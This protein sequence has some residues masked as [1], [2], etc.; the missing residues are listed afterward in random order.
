[1]TDDFLSS[2]PTEVYSS[3]ICRH[4]TPLLMIYLLLSS[5]C[6]RLIDWRA[7][8]MMSCSWCIFTKDGM[9]FFNIHQ[10][11]YNAVDGCSLTVMKNYKIVW[12][13]PQAEFLY[14]SNI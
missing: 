5:L 11:F 6:Q 13:R 9:P 2:Q 14:Y 4:S 1:M 10:S 12:D 3:F 8:E 7:L